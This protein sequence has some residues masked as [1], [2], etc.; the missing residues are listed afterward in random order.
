MISLLLVGAGQIGSRHLQSLARLD[1]PAHVVVVEP[2]AQ[3]RVVAQQRWS[4]AGGSNSVT[5]VPEIP[6]GAFEFALVATTAKVRREAIERLLARAAV[7]FLLLEKVLFQKLEDYDSVGALLKQRRVPAWV[8]CAQRYWP[9]FRKAKQAYAAGGPIELQVDG[10]NWGL[11]CNAIHNLDLLPFLTGETA[12][13]LSA[14]LDPGTVSAKRPGFIE[15]TGTLVAEDRFGNRVTQTSRREGDAPFDMRLTGPG[16]TLTLADAAVPR[17]SELTRVVVR[18]LLDASSC[19]LP[20]YAESAAVHQQMLKVF[21]AHEG[22][23][24]VCRI[25]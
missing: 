15:F 13:R 21:L 5:F 22:R 12:M 7:R 24:S 2:S 3:A 14:R 20:S 18:Q 17:Q 11:G 8:N 23:D 16:M 25:T 1:P 6:E 19:E 9:M 10:A 4:E